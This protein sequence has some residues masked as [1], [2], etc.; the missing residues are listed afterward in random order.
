MK[1]CKLE[2]VDS[3]N[4]YGTMNSESV[5]LNNITD[6]DKH[7][8]MIL[9]ELSFDEVSKYELTPDDKR[10]IFNIHRKHLGDDYDFDWHKMFMADQKTKDGSYFEITKDY[11]EANPDGWS[12]ISEDILIVTE[13]IPGVVIGHPVADCPVIVMEDKRKGVTAM[14]HCSADLIDK[15]MPMMIA[16][17]LSDAYNSSDD[18]I[19]AYVSACAGESWTYDK[20]PGFAKDDRLWKS[21]IIED[22]NGMFHINLRKAIA[23]EMQDRNIKNVV[24]ASADTITNPEY[25]SNSAS[26]PHGLND[27]SKFGRNFIGAFYQENV[28]IKR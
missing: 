17:A 13:K 16:D 12:D 9:H 23:L 20:Y 7:L 24:Y 21:G 3:K 15:K 5:N 10:V 6:Y 25:Y 2:L 14:A 1:N 4:L 27:Q 18:D 22:K 11:V 8:M 26:S 19:I 28:K